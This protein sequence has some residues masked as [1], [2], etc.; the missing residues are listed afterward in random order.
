MDFK[1]NP[2][3]QN[4]KVVRSRKDNLNYFKRKDP[5]RDGCPK[6]YGHKIPLQAREAR[7]INILWKN[8]GLRCHQI[9]QLLDRS[10][11]LIH[12]HLKKVSAYDVTIRYG[13]VY[14][15]RKLAYNT[16]SLISRIVWKKALQLW[17]L[18]EMY[19]NGDLDEPP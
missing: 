15:I 6:K 5:C 2:K 9:A 18:W 10:T 4:Y 8:A 12:N 13:G 19:L 17:S 14:N 11:S 7:A 16:H 1:P 3:G